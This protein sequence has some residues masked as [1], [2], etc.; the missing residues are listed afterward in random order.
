MEILEKLGI[1]FRLL[2]AQIINFGILIF[3]LYRFAY[4]PIIR[5]LDNR[6]KRIEQSL[7]DAKNIEHQQVVSEE[8]YNA[9]QAEAQKQA[10]TIVTQ[11]RGQA[12]QLKSEMLKSAKTDAQVLLEQTQ[13]EA[14][15]LKAQ[16]IDEAKSELADLVV[17]STEK[18]IGQK[19]TAEKDLEFIRKTLPKL[20]Q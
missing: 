14:R 15:T 9:R 16:A 11:A 19:M 3:L 1:D 8:A 12:E 17:A 13:E 7:V 10:D 2:I 4:R 6:A 20:K 5:V 18:I